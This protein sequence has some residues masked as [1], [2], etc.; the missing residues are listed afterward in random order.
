VKDDVIRKVCER[1]VERFAD[2]KRSVFNLANFSVAWTE[3]TGLKG[4]IDGT[5]AEAILSG[6]SD[7][8]REGVLALDLRDARAFKRAVCREFVLR[9]IH[10]GNPCEE[11][12]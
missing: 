2:P 9:D 8:Y 1:A 7:V 3:I 11:N 12:P 10:G 6:R 4:G 5:A